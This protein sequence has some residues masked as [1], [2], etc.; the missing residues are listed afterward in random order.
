MPPGTAIPNI[1]NQFGPDSLSLANRM[2]DM[3]SIEPLGE[4]TST[5]DA[6]KSF[7]STVL[8]IGVEVLE[9][10]LDEMWP[11]TTAAESLR[12]VKNIIKN[13]TV[14]LK[15]Y[16]LGNVTIPFFVDL[17]SAWPEFSGQFS[18]R[19]GYMG[20]SRRIEGVRTNTFPIS[21]EKSMKLC[22]S[23]RG[24]FRWVLM[25]LSMGMEWRSPRDFGWGS[26]R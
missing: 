2:G 17:F 18:H 25:R 15:L 7:V 23:S 4:G 3:I 16:D 10:I 1:A 12:K 9:A 13:V 6:I 14:V 22:G 8:D 21:G 19:D 20:L 11:H 26:M 24:G 5:F